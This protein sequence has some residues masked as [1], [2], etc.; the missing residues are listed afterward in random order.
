MI[1]KHLWSFAL[2]PEYTA[3]RGISTDVRIK[4][5]ASAVFWNLLLGIGLAIL[6]EGIFISLGIEQGEHKTVEMFSSYSL[7]QVFLLMVILA[8]LIEESLFRG[9]L[10][11]FRKSPYFP[12]A[13]YMSCILFGLVHLGN[14]ENSDHLL[15]WTPLLVAPQTLMGFFL[16]FLR[17]RLGLEYAILMHMAHNGLLFL[18]ISFTEL[19]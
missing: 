12:F 8:P 9:P 14:F 4:V 6:A 17:V 5:L 3:Y 15:P 11:F 2:K 10:V 13:F 16:G 19:P 7:P 18:L 1:L